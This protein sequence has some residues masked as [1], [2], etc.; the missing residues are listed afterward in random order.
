MQVAR[1]GGEVSPAR[2]TD[3]RIEEFGAVASGQARRRIVAGFNAYMGALGDGRYEAA[4]AQLAKRMHKLLQRLNPAGTRDNCPRGLASLPE[5]IKREVR[6]AAEAKI[7]AVRVDGDVA[8]V[9]ID[10]QATK[11]AQMPMHREA[12]RWKVGLVSQVPVLGA[13]P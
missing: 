2:T 10:V 11:P 3:A 13:N 5:K 8:H 1:G 7:A 4:C 9:V 12:R 6:R